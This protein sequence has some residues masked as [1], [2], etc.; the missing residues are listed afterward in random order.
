MFGSVTEIRLIRSVVLM[1]SD[2]PT[3]TRNG[4]DPV[5]SG[6]DCALAAGP[7]LCGFAACSAAEMVV[8]GIESNN[9]TISS[10]TLHRQRISISLPSPPLEP[11]DMAFD[12]NAPLVK[13]CPFRAS[14]LCKSR[15]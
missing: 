15:S 12:R 3:M 13:N 9:R 11:T 1:R 4:A 5:P 8:D 6:A 2:L 14:T 7:V 10:G